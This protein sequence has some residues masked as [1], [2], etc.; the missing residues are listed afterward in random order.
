MLATW[1]NKGP[2][3]DVTV[4]MRITLTAKRDECGGIRHSDIFTTHGDRTRRHT[5]PPGPSAQCEGTMQDISKSGLS[6]Y[7]DDVKS[8]IRF[9]RVQVL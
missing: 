1:L 2:A 7:E 5:R 6:L 3:E 4:Q 9:M 8:Q